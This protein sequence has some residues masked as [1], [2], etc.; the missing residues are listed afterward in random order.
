MC[1]QTIQDTSWS[2]Q[3][4]MIFIFLELHIIHL[5]LSFTNRVFNTNE[6]HHMSLSSSQSVSDD[7]GLRYVGVTTC[8][9]TL[10]KWWWRSLLVV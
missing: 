3:K 4:K 5:P 8:F 1:A 6:I 7:S 9:S 2:D 10:G